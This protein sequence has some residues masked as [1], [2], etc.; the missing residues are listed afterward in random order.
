MMVRTS[1]YVISFEST[2]I[3][4][5]CVQRFEQVESSL[6]ADGRTEWQLFIM[7]NTCSMGAL[8]PLSRVQ[9][10]KEWIERIMFLWFFLL[11]FA[12]DD[13]ASNK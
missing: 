5:S 9:V 6:R 3:K 8:V 12:A 11:T 13:R 2:I 1:K 7:V 10:P 4:A